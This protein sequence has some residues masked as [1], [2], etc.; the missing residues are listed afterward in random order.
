MLTPSATDALEMAA[1]LVEAGP[2]D[3]VLMPSFTHPATANAFVRRGATP[4]FVDIRPDTLNLDEALVGSA[5]GPRTKAVVAVHYGGIACEMGSLAGSI[6]GSDAVL[7]E[8]VAHG[9]GS[10]WRGR[11]LGSL[12]TFA[13]LSF[14]AT[15]DVICGEGGA[16]VVNNPGWVER[17]EVV[18]ENG[19]NRAAF[20]RG[21]ADEYTWI[22][23]GSSFLAGEIGAAF[24]W[25]Q[26]ERSGE[27]L[28]ARRSIWDGYH[29][30]FADLEASGR[31]RRP[32]VPE[33]CDPNG[34][35]YYLLL[36]DRKDR[37]RLIGAVAADGVEAAFHYVPLHSSPAGQRYGQT[38]GDLPVT[39]EA[40]DRL[41]R[42]PLWADMGEPELDAVV[43]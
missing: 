42:Q 14:H 23:E 33:G 12:G 10:A 31:I 36:E 21:E 27:I 30:A 34:H 6:E 4:V 29:G 15:K 38:H 20:L 25:G 41:V 35:L 32:V 5:I 9:L 1:I 7:I 3:E 19:T 40:G 2:G 8:D 26:L 37:D 17:A 11:P 13:T 16:L 24:L 28:S 39:D 43:G 18:Q 22:G